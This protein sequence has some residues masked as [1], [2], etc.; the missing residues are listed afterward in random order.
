MWTRLATDCFVDPDW[1]A[2]G[3]R[4]N[5]A[6]M[7]RTAFLALVTSWCGGLGALLVV[8]IALRAAS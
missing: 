5:R 1:R 8:A 7:S 2:P 6:E 4:P 3:L